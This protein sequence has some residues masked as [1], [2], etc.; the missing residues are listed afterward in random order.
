ME[1]IRVRVDE[2][3]CGVHGKEPDWAPGA[4][5]LLKLYCIA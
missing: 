1:P 5:P 3:A 4:L 2:C